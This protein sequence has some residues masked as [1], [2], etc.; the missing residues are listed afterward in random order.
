LTGKKQDREKTKETSFSSSY[1]L[2]NVELFLMFQMFFLTESLFV[3]AAGIFSTNTSP[4][5]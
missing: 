4:L 2:K 5:L 1:F 3:G